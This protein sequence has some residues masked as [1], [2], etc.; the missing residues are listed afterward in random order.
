MACGVLGLGIVSVLNECGQTTELPRHCLH[1]I[2]PARYCLHMR[3][4]VKALLTQ[5]SGC[6]VITCEPESTYTLFGSFL[7]STPRSTSWVSIDG[8]VK[9]LLTVHTIILSPCPLNMRLAQPLCCLLCGWAYKRCRVPSGDSGPG[10]LCGQ[11]G[12]AHPKPASLVLNSTLTLM[13]LPASVS[14]SGTGVRCTLCHL[15]MQ[16]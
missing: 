6:R 11:Q 3:V 1:M 7:S 13:Q 2:G 4:P 5:D 14:V 10:T 8:D 12:I 9:G 15:T 16:V